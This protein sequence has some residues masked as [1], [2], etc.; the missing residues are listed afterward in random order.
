MHRLLLALRASFACLVALPLPAQNCGNTS[1][2]L[3]PVVDLGSGQYQGFTGGLYAGG[4]N[5]R[6]AAHDAAGVAI[7]RALPPRD[8]AGTP[9]PL[10]G[11]IVILSIGMSNT[12]QEFSTW[13]PISNA[14]PQRSPRVQ[15]VD[16]AQGGQDAPTIANPN[17]QFW[18]VVNQRLAAAGATPQQVQVFWL[19]EAVAGPRTAF[20]AHAVEL[21][22]YLRAI[23]NNL[24]TK[25][26]NA[27]ICYLSSRIYAGYATT[28]LNPEPYA[29][30][31]AF[32]VKWLIEDQVAGA[33]DL[34]YD[35]TRGPVRSPWLSWGPY[36]WADG[37]VPRGDGLTWICSDF[38][39]DGTH[40]GP[41]GRQKVAQMLDQHFRSDSTSTPWYLGAG[42]PRATV[43]V[44]GDGCPGTVGVPQLRWSSV[45]YLGNP[46]FAFGVMSARSLSPAFLLLSA[47]RANLILAGPCRLFVDPLAGFFTLAGTTDGGGRMTVRFPIPNDQGL[48]GAKVDAQWLVLDPMGTG[49]LGLSIAMSA[50]A[51]WTA[52]VQ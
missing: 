12:T 49:F 35:A 38:A 41:T 32:S 28:A 51:E 20:P 5:A 26:P 29:Y 33:A 19:K 31:S 15:V 45:P 23:C 11:K 27:A 4:S 17:A 1:V 42:P 2:G 46:D 44:Y 37:T 24:Q 43:A 9:D 22:G 21:Q 8:A 50:G 40:P 52:G 6:P 13:I 3:T 34:N 16:G 10:Q 14:D 47:A 18:T 25:F 39:N 7:A 30:E 36:L 48:A